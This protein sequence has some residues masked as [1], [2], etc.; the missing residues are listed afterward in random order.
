MNVWYMAT[1]LVVVMIL[2]GI[3]APEDHHKKQDKHKP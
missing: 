2:V 1:A 3:F